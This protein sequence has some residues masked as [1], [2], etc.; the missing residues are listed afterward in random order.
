MPAG[1]RFAAVRARDFSI[2]LQPPHEPVVAGMPGEGAVVRVTDRNDAAGRSDAAHLLQ[3]CYWIGEVLQQ[4]MCVHDVKRGI[5]NVQPVHV[6]CYER[7][8]R[9]IAPR[10]SNDLCRRIDPGDGTGGDA[11]SEI[12]GNCPRTTPHVQQTDASAQ[13]WQQ[14]GRRVLDR[15]PT[16]GSQDAFVM[17][18]RVHAFSAGCSSPVSSPQPLPYGIR[19]N[20]ATLILEPRMWPSIA[21]RMSASVAPPGRSSFVSSANRL[22]R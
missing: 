10:F 4:L 14:V 11:S 19:S 15:S 20:A 21:L 1:I 12:G 6:T 16:M 7:D 13:M 22:K 2:E 18:V 9:M 5:R 17:T 3:G 8:P